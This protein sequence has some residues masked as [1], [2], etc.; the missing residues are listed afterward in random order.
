MT[1]FICFGSGSSGNCYYLRADGYGLVIDLG[2]G[3]RVF[4]KYFRDYGLPLAQIGAVLVTHDHTDHV[5][6]VGS[7]SNE[8]HLPVYSSPEVHAG[9]HRNHFMSR[10]V[11]K[12]DVRHLAPGESV[13]VGPFTVTIFPVPHDSAG[14]NGY[15]IEKDAM[16]LCLLT[17]AGHVTPEMC[18]YI[19][20]ANYLI[21]ESNYDKTMLETGPY[22][23]YLKKRISGP[24]GHLSNDEC[25]QTLAAH[26]GK[27]VRHVW[28]C[29]LSEE[30]NR[31][32]LACHAVFTQLEAA[33]RELPGSLTV[34]ALKRTAPSPLYTLE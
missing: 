30:N 6:S 7:L 21:V 18:D 1:E 17:D 33:G 31:P 26:M 19:R 23:P 8:F 15:L 24:A 22:P 13:R 20:R 32:E 9:M 28:L 3:I 27:D 10:K 29:H 14:N 4:K 16:R 12:D 5:K 34:E 25:A 11:N 2:L